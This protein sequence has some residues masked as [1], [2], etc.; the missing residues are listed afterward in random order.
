MRKTD[1]ILQIDR[2]MKQAFGMWEAATD[3]TFSLKSSGSV[4][5]E[6]RFEK[7]ARLTIRVLWFLFLIRFVKSEVKKQIGRR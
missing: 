2:T 6:V 7:P 5:I 3:L 4:H 1:K